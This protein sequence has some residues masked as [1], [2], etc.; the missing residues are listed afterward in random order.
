LR[1]IED[2]EGFGS[3]LKARFPVEG[4][5]ATDGNIGL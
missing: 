3:K 4:E 1:V 2:I 5:L